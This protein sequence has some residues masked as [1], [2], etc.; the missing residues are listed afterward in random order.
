MECENIKPR[1]EVQSATSSQE[2]V[3]AVTK[4][5]GLPGFMDG[6]DNLDN[7]LLQF[8]RCSTI[9]GWQRDTWAVRLSP[10][11]T[12]KALNVYS[13]LSSEDARD[14][15]KLR[16]ALI[17]RYDFTE[18]GYRDRF[19]EAKPEGQESPGQ[20]IVRIRNYFDKWVKLSEVGKT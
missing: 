3:A 2:N 16:K 11:L 10:L 6:K 20:L 9:A 12:G 15:N 5:I 17:Q 14:Y 13:G 19:R 7:Y 8:E 1:T 4:T 18:Q